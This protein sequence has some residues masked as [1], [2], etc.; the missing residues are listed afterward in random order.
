MKISFFFT[1]IL[2]L[3]F[4]YVFSQNIKVSGKVTDSNNFPI[5]GGNIIEKGTTNSTQTDIDG[6]YT[7]KVRPS[8]T[9]TFSCMGMKTQ[10]IKVTNTT[11]NIVMFPEP[12]QMAGIVVTALGIK[13]EKKAVG[14]SVQEIKGQTISQA[15]QTNAISALSGNIAGIQVT[16]PSSMGG[17]TRV[18]IRGVGSL[19][20][21]NRPLIVIDG[22][23]MDDSNY[24]SASTH[25]GSGGIDYGDA[26]ADINPDDIESVSVLKG[27]P[28]AALYGSRAANGVIIYTTKSGKKGK[29]EITL[30]TGLAIENIY[31]MPKLQNEY[32]GGSSNEMQTATING[33]LYNLTDYSMDESWGPKYNP[34][35]MYLPWS[36]FDPE[37]PNDYLVPK[38][39]IAPKKDIIS[40]FNTGYT[41]TNNIA[42]SHAAKN[43]NIRVAISNQN[44]TGIVPNTRLT[45]N[46]FSIKGGALLHTKLRFD[47]MLSY[48]STSGFNRPSQGYD[49]NSVSQKFFQWGQRQLDFDN[50]KN[51]KLPN[52]K[53]RTWNRTSW[54]DPTPLYSDNPYWMIYEN[55]SNDKRNRYT[56]NVKLKYNFT[57]N[58]YGV[59][60]IYGDQY[61]FTIRERTAVY[62]HDMS[63]YSQAIRLFSE[64]NYEAR[65]HFDKR[66]NKFSSNTFIGINRRDNQYQAISGSTSGGLIIPNLY[67]LS[68]SKNLAVST[69]YD[70]RSRV[71]SFYASLS[72]G[73]A[74]MLYLEATNRKD[75]FSTISRPANYPS[76]TGSFIFSELLSDVS[77][78]S[79]GKIR[80]GWAKVSNGA[81]PYS[82]T[83]YF[84][85]NK[86]FHSIPTYFNNTRASNPDL[87][88]ETKT[89]KEIG[90]EAQFF[91]NRIGLDIALYEETTRNLIT[92]L[93]V[94][95]T[96][97]YYSKYINAGKLQNRGIEVTLSSTPIAS[98]NFTWNIT[99]NFSKNDNKLLSLYQNTKSMHLSSAPFRVDLLAVVGERYGQL[100]GHDFA[101]D[102]NGYKIINPNGTYKTGARKAL[103][104]IIPDY[105]IG[106]RNAFTYKKLTLRFL[107]DIQKGGSYFS[108]T[109]MHGQSN[110]I[111][112]ETAANGIRENGII[113]EGVLENGMPNTK[114]LSA[115]SWGKAHKNSIDA[116]NVFDASYFKLREITFS[117]KLPTQA[118]R[119]KINQVT[120]SVFA[121]NFLVW[122]LRWN[123]MDPENTSYG[124]GNIQGLEGGSLPS[125]RTYGLN[126][127]IKI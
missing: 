58:L 109:Y 28:A 108:T 4:P 124:S 56:G 67:H 122:G 100:Y 88:P 15:G 39:W 31:I 105:N 59:A 73:Y 49:N 16:A 29:S 123:G 1:L 90:L 113:L 61:D 115:Y 77:W 57:K 48:I 118:F 101:Y 38:P 32:G 24:N 33:R 95:T 111:L 107:L 11:L 5:P 7:I 37:F 60:N 53:Q 34:D 69:N 106:I 78:L 21:N 50:L 102:E 52:G 85:I 99:G 51:Y 82:T 70:S 62:S 27:G 92:P 6:N 2:L 20:Q 64:M 41:T 97:G 103:G 116:Q 83:D 86:P 3:A 26:S 93:Q 74:N 94:T 22:I 14:Y 72:I 30:K 10:E 44:T 68:N 40:F 84:S 8:A 91:Q 121:R 43:N 65:L 55:T 80:Y 81:N 13:R 126:I 76:V 12:T 96:T 25:R 119:D 19:T 79:F 18:L 120:L 117:Y 47:G 45:R 104:C 127:E 46:T 112:E 36:A 54:S 71:N 98:E 66:W 9:L 87:I 110:G 17:S 75:W 114:V 42:L 125:T 63:S 89:S 23:P 35:L